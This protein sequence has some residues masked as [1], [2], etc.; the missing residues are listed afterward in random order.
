MMYQ[1]ARVETATFRSA[2]A[3][4]FVTAAY[5]LVSVAITGLAA[6]VQWRWPVRTR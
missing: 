1:A 6:L 2:E 4:V 5:L 3:F